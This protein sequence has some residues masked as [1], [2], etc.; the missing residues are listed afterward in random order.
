[1]SHYR[2]GIDVGWI[3]R[4][5][6]VVLEGSTWFVKMGSCKTYRVFCKVNV[7]GS[8]LLKSLQLAFINFLPVSRF[9]SC[10]CKEATQGFLT[11]TDQGRGKEIGCCMAM[12]SIV[13]AAVHSGLTNL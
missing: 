13:C 12:G 8:L 1:M 5:S 3:S 2:S 6:V 10:G 11:R 9:S 7:N 4:A